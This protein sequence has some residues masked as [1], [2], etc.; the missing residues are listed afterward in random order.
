MNP[1]R[2]HDLPALV[3]GL[4]ASLALLNRTTASG[5]EPP[6]PAAQR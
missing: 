1:R 3:V 4:M 5:G 2:K 6:R